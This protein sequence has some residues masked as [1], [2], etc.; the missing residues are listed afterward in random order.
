[1]SEKIDGFLQQ[2][3]HFLFLGLFFFLPLIFWIP[4]SE[5][6]ELPKMYFV[7]AMTTLIIG[8]WLARMAVRR[9][10]LI[11]KTPLDI[12]ILLFLLSQIASTINSIDPHVSWFGWYGRFNGGLIST[13]SYT[14]LYYALVSNLSVIGFLFSVFSFKSIGRQ[15]TGSKPMDRKPINHE[16]ITDNRELITAILASAAIV[17]LYAILQ[18]FGID[19]DFWIQDVMNRVFSTQGQPNWLAGYI[20]MVAPLA[21]A[22]TIMSNE[23]KVMSSGITFYFLLIIFFTTLLFAKS[24][25]GLLGLAVA[26]VV[27]WILIFIRFKRFRKSFLLIHVLMLILILIT[28]NPVKDFFLKVSKNDRPLTLYSVLRTPTPTKSEHGGT[29]SSDIRRLVWSGALKIAQQNPIFGT[30]P[31]TF[32]LTYWQVRPKEANLTSEWNFLYNKAHNEWLNLAANTGLFGLGTHLLLLGWFTAWTL[33]K[34]MS[35]KQKTMTTDNPLLI[36]HCSLLIA[37]LSA[38][39]GVETVNFFG[40]STV[41]VG[42]YRYLFMAWA[43]I[44]ESNEQKVMSNEKTQNKLLKKIPLLSTFYFLLIIFASFYLLLQIS[45]LYFADLKYNLGRQY[46]SAGYISESLEQFSQSVNLVPSEPVFR[47]EL[48]ES[49]SAIAISVW[50][51]GNKDQAEKIKA[52]A[53]DN[54]KTV[55]NQSEFNLTFLR[56]RAQMEFLM[57]EI[58]PSLTEE[59]LKLAQKAIDLSPTDPR[60]YYLLGRMYDEIGEKS[61]AQE[62]YRQTLELKSDYEEARKAILINE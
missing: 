55:S 38:I 59:S 23:Q 58:D 62:L 56:T 60:G 3:I 24:R 33:K 14:L 34:T 2:T 8:C 49:L 44:V 39:L 54:F 11:S 30:G 51:D 10:I 52:E 32:G 61:K 29:E 43:V 19:R 26:D 12:P 1:M 50:A 45:H 15:S 35:R 48:A 18:H 22:M 27:F 6:F 28:N 53:V 20:V 40:F 42:T 4:N 7:N 17:S 46:Y 21:L 36:A 41:T 16:P 31:E 9:E 37:L 47:N 13:I 25:S 57:R 5:V